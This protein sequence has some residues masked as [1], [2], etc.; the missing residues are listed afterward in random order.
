MAD[1]ETSVEPTKVRRL[2]LVRH[3]RAEQDGPTDFDRPLHPEGVTDAADAGAWLRDAG[4]VADAALISAAV[5]A[6][7]TWEAIAEAAGWTCEATQDRG[8][9]TAGPEA[10][11]DLVRATPDPVTTLVVVGHNPT[12]ATAAQLLD[13]G[14]GDAAAIAEM[15]RGYPAGALAA[16]ELAG[17]WSQ[18]DWDTARLVGFHVGQ[19]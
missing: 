15:L 10:A 5:R 11:L 19:G 3:A 6:V 13:D 9:Y 16:F 17:S 2:V 7:Q 8:L 4:F 18:L 12:I 1:P 14:D